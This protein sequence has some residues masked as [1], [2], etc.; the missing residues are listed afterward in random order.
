MEKKIKVKKLLFVCGFNQYFG[1]NEEYD[2]VNQS[3]YLDHLE[4]V[5]QYANE[6]ICFY[7]NNDP[8]VSYEAEKD[9]ADQIATEQVCIPNAGHINSESGFDTF[10]DLVSY[11]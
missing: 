4:E 7:S 1:I 8:Y 9:F 10:E 11:L 5:K 3:M 6:I 2:T